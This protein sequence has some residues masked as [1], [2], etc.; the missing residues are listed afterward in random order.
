MKLSN[1]LEKIAEQLK[2]SNEPSQYTMKYV[3]DIF[4]DIHYT[5]DKMQNDFKRILSI[6]KKGDKEKSIATI[7]HYKKQCQKD[8]KLLIDSID[9]VKNI[10]KK[11]E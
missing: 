10:L 9:G 4:S 3:A 1:E 7:D 2:E 8:N 6:L 11:I 5:F